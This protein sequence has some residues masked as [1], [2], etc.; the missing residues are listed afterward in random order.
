MQMVVRVPDRNHSSAL[1][2]DGDRFLKKELIGLNGRCE[3]NPIKVII[4]E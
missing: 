1:K 2:F 3:M 4:E